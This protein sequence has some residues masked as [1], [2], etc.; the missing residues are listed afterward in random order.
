MPVLEMEGYDSAIC[1]FCGTEICFI[2]KQTR[3]GP[4]GEGDY[5]GGCKCGLDGQ[6]CHPDCRGCNY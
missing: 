3:W 2:T 6:F 1:E 4:S 5:S